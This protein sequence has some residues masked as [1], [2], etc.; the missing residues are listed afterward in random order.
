MLGIYDKLPGEA[1]R[2]FRPKVMYKNPF[3]AGF[4]RDEDGMEMDDY[5]CLFRCTNFSGNSGA[6]K[7]AVGSY[8]KKIELICPDADKCGKMKYNWNRFRRHIT[9]AI[10]EARKEYHEIKVAKILR[11]M[12]RFLMA[13]KQN[14]DECMVG[15]GQRD[16][17]EEILYDIDRSKLGLLSCMSYCRVAVPK[18]E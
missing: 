18:D 15:S 12:Y 9:E 4:I 11:S 2:A 16:V 1:K 6:R 5:Y 10:R 3:G 14:V 7:I 17:C 8:G 13:F